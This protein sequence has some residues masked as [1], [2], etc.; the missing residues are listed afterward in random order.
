MEEAELLRTVLQDGHYTRSWG[1]TLVIT[2]ER[3]EREDS[4]GSGKERPRGH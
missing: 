4:E 1:F 2:G 3:D